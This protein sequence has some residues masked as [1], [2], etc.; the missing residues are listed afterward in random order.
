VALFCLL[1]VGHANVALASG[2]DDPVAPSIATIDKPL[3]EVGIG[4]VAG[5]ITDY[6]GSDRYQVRG[7]PLPYFIYR[8]SFLRSDQSGTRLRASSGIVEWEFSGGGSLSSNSQRG[9]RAGMP[10]L[11]YLLEAGPQAKITIARPTDTSRVL[12]DLPVRAA[13][14]TNF[15]SRFQT[16]GATFSPDVTLEERSVFGSQWNGRLSVG[17]E[18]AT[19]GLQQFYYGVAPQFA[20]PGRPA[21]QAHGG[22]LSSSVS[23]AAFRRLRKHFNFFIAL[24][25]DAYQGAASRTSP[26]FRSSTGFGG[27]VGF[28]WSFKQSKTLAFDPQNEA[29]Q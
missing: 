2:E 4:V 24:D 1:F 20:E 29:L 22:Y 23:L 27:A 11:D 6:P 7:L 25:F 13:A 15:S 5:A 14:S 18:F 12:I 8:G 28:A 10:K 3:W 9:A 17:V 21:Y 16:R 26:L 19:Q